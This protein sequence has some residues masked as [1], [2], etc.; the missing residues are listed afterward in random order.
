[1][2]VVDEVVIKKLNAR[3]RDGVSPFAL[4]LREH[5]PQ[6]RVHQIELN[7]S[8]QVE[9]KVGAS[10]GT[11]LLEKPIYVLVEKIDAVEQRTVWPVK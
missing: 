7:L 4:D 5:V 11:D 10:T 3:Q 8:R 1:M 9:N 2:R 6:G